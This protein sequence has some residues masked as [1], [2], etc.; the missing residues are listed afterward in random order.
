[1]VKKILILSTLT[2]AALGASAQEVA[3]VVSRVPIVQ[4]VAVPRQVCENQPVVVEQPTSGAGGLIGAVAGGILGHQVGGGSG[5]TAATAVG[6]LAGAVV[7]D[8]VEAGNNR[9]AQMAPRCTTQNVYENRTVGYDVRYEYAGRQ[10]QTRTVNDPGPSI[11]VQV[12]PL[13]DQPPP[14]AAS[15]PA[16]LPPAPMPVYQQRY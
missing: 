10:Y 14:V 3:A 6:V 15:M 2:L 9:Q 16:P 12:V 13:V 4:Q 7:G 11:R 8:R 1:M 5:K